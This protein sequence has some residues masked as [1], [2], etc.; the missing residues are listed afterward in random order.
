MLGGV[1]LSVDGEPCELNNRITYK[2]VLVEGI[3]NL[4]W[5]FGYTNAPWTLKSDISGAY[6]CRLLEH[7]EAN[8]YAVA[9]P[10]DAENCATD[11][12]VL[13][14]FQAGYVQRTKEIMPRQGAKPPWK[15]LMDYPKDCR[16]LLEDPIDDGV[17]SFEKSSDLRALRSAQRA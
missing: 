5:F 14:H 2:G 4:G 15:V 3:P 6:L 9:T 17:L 11:V 13:D 10:R 16:I 8:G 12:G 1:R 7:M